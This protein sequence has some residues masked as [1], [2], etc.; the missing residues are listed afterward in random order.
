MVSYS[1]I[2][3]HIP[4]FGAP[5]ISDHGRVKLEISNINLSGKSLNI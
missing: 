1:F 4:G 3:T 5:G 2:N